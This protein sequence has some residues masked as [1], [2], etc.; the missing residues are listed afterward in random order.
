MNFNV[1]LCNYTDTNILIDE[2][3]IDRIDKTFEQ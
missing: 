2:S 3:F 1:K